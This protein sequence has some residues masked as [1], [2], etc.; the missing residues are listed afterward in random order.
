MSVFKINIVYLDQTSP[1]PLVCV[2]KES[3][4][5]VADSLGDSRISLYKWKKELLGK[6]DKKPMD[7]SGNPPLCDDKDA[8][9]A[10]VE[11]LKKEIYRKQM[12]LDILKKAAEIIKKD[13]GINPRK[14]K[15]KEKTSLIDALRTEYSLF[16]L[17]RYAINKCFW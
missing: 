13:Q 16:V 15:N 17:F 5:A 1:C 8:L 4:A 7:G 10:E 3:A 6:E 2:R 14:L 12:E 9:L 11:L